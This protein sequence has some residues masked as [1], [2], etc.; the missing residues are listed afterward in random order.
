MAISFGKLFQPFLLSSS[1]A[2]FFSV[3][4]SPST[5]LLGNGR[6]RLVNTSAAAVA[7]TLF[8]VPS[9]QGASASNAFVDNYSIA[10]YSAYTVDIPQIAA[11]D[12]LLGF[13]STT[14][15][16]AVHAMA[17]VIQS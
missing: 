17:G 4:A 16:I 10:A 15:V 1:P 3:P 9:G 14:N 2:S 5:S 6:L 7:V 8:A 12:A 13:A 11:G